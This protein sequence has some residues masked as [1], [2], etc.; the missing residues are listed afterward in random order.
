MP[1]ERHYLR[2]AAVSG[3]ISKKHGSPPP[4]RAFPFFKLNVK[5]PQKGFLDV[6]DYAGCEETCL[7]KIK[8]GI[9]PV[10]K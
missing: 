5:T 2:P 9:A 1:G 7:L 6:L 8:N 3:C 10:L 4:V